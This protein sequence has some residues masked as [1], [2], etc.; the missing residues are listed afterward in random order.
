MQ[1][2]N[3]AETLPCTVVH[4]HYHHH[5]QQQYYY[6]YHLLPVGV[7]HCDQSKYSYF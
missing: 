1:R 2:R 5:H 4:Q 3:Q 6:Q 7:C